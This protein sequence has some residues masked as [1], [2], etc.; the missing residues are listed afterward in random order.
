MLT[1]SFYD[2]N[3][4]QITLLV[5]GI[6]N[7]NGQSKKEQ[8]RYLFMLHLFQG[9]VAIGQKKT[10]LYINNLCPTHS[11]ENHLAYKIK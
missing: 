2:F 7:K 9:L 11:P 5:V 8:E 6:P 1:G 3:P 4:D 10:S